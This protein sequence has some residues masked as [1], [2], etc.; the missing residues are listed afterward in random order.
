MKKL[1]FE[2]YREAMDGVGPKVKEIILEHAAQ[3]GNL[4]FPDFVRLCKLA[5]PE[6]V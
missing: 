4:E 2:D 1:T 3:Y 6:S 5:D